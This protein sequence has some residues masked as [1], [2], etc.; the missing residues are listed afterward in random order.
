MVQAVRCK[1]LTSEAGFFLWLVYV[2]FV[3]D[4]VTMGK[5]FSPSTSTLPV[6]VTPHMLPTHVRLIA[7]VISWRN[8]GPGTFHFRFVFGLQM[9]VYTRKIT[10]GTF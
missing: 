2:R 7:S 9:V 10:R 5:D 6:S 1:P 4:V 3:E 8:G